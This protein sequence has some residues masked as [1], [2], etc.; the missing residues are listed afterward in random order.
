M[1]LSACDFDI[2]SGVSL[3]TTVFIVGNIVASDC[4]SG[5]TNVSPAVD[6]VEDSQ[7]QLQPVGGARG[8]S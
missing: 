3:S 2:S 6:T 5:K 4:I 1:I 7:S 8:A